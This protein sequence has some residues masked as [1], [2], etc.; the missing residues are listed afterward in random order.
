[1]ENLEQDVTRSI[2]LDGVFRFFRLSDC[3][4]QRVFPCKLSLTRCLRRRH[5]VTPGVLFSHRGTWHWS[6]GPQYTVSLSHLHEVF[7]THPVNEIPVL[8][9]IRVPCYLFDL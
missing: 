8:N 7:P 2:R 6:L 4:G 9:T 3:M 1:M 5:R